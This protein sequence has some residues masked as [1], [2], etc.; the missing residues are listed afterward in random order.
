MRLH[1]QNW[2]QIVVWK[3]KYFVISHPLLYEV[4]ARP[5]FLC[6]CLLGSDLCC[7]DGLLVVRFE[8]I[9]SGA[10]TMY[11]S[12]KRK[13]VLSDDIAEHNMG[14]TKRKV[15]FMIEVQECKVWPLVMIL[16]MSWW[17]YW[18]WKTLI[19]NTQIAGDHPSSLNIIVLTRRYSLTG[20]IEG[21]DPQLSRIAGMCVCTLFNLINFINVY[22]YY[23]MS[24]CTTFF[25]LFFQTLLACQGYGLCRLYR[26]KMESLLVTC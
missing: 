11:F 24:F 10:K 17:D 14:L 8:S 16:F 5:S 6:S 20:A 2:C 9:L 22:L 21:V 13:T 3:R 25:I 1:V 7:V 4:K 12:F 23:S 18:C 15:L 26:V 19:N